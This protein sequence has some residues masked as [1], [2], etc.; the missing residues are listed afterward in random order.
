[1]ADRKKC[2]RCNDPVARGCSKHCA[3]CSHKAVTPGICSRCYGPKPAQKGRQYCDECRDL[4]KW[5]NDRLKA[6][7][8]RKTCSDCGGPKPPGHGRIWCPACVKRRRKERLTVQPVRIC[9]DCDS[10]VGKRRT[11]CDDC[12]DLRARQSAERK[13]AKAKAWRA[14]TPISKRRRT[15]KAKHKPEPMVLALQLGEAVYRC[16]LKAAGI[17]RVND[18]LAAELLE[19]QREAVRKARERDEEHDPK[20]RA[21]NGSAL[22]GHRDVC[23]RAGIFE[24]TAFGWR[25]GEREKTSL[26]VATDVMARLDLLW[27]DVWNLDTVRK[28][29]F[30]AVVYKNVKPDPGRD[31]GPWDADTICRWMEDPK[32]MAPAGFKRVTL[33][34]KSYIDLGPDRQEL[35]TIAKTFEGSRPRRAAA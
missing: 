6:L 35:R 14:A 32:A 27:W 2:V 8:R 28:H 3:K 30:K 34:S 9:A 29:K 22:I 15:R 11:Y 4:E 12:R 16:G 7:H 21:C 5:K 17:R 20:P 10:P 1:M 24:R 25:S 31:L 18:E 26:S 13:K 23:Q 33:K 19:R